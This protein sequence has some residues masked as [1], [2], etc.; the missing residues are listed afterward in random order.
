MAET[1]SLKLPQFIRESLKCSGC[2]G[3][4]SVAPIVYHDRGLLCGRC[5]P[6]QNASFQRAR[7]YETLAQLFKFPC[8][9]SEIGC[10][11][12]LD[13][14]SIKLHEANCQF[15]LIR[16]PVMPKGACFWNGRKDM[17]VAHFGHYHKELIIN[18]SSYFYLPYK[19]D[20]EVNKLMIHEGSFFVLQIRNDVQQGKCWLGLTTTSTENITPYSIEFKA[21]ENSNSMVLQ[22]NVECDAT[23]SWTMDA[24]K[25]FSLDISTIKSF[26]DS[27]N[28]MCKLEIVHNQNKKEKESSKPKN[29]IATAQK[30]DDMMLKE[31]ECLV[32][33]EYM[34]PPIF[35]CT[36]GHSICGSCRQTKGIYKC[37]VCQ[38]DVTNTRNFALEN[39]TT[40]AQYPCKN[41]AMGCKFSGNST[42]IRSHE[43]QCNMLHVECP[44]NCNWK[45]NTNS[46]ID[47]AQ[48][49]HNINTPWS[50]SDTLFRNLRSSVVVDYYLVKW[51]KKIFKVGFKH[52]S[53]TGPVHWV[54]Q[55][56]GRHFTDKPEYKFTLKFVDQSDMGRQFII[57]NLCYGIGG[58]GDFYNCTIIP[59]QLLKPYINE[60]D[61]LIFQLNIQKIRVE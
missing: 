58:A 11:E 41:K 47:H 33:F 10:T 3:Y 51:D 37:P 26:L 53:L 60:D 14:N 38:S 1:V 34:I 55:E 4:L 23:A 24:A 6:P 42:N 12:E 21:A 13:W 39:V 31:L 57:N 28:I 20:V 54:V 35:I 2:S 43:K 32:C 8:K 16:C 25:S 44:F 49:Q 52:S 27:N 61:Q 50:L 45:G 40:A 56:L 22:K 17:L 36:G 59:Y 30:N 7:A 29:T 19:H 18:V 48:K 15:H 5:I 46:V 9:N